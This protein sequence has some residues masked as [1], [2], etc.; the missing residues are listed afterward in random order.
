MLEVTGAPA[1]RP[2][3]NSDAPVTSSWPVVRLLLRL[4]VALSLVGFAF[5]GY[6]W[7]IYP[8]SPDARSSVLGTVGLALGLGGAVVMAFTW[9]YLRPLRDALA[10]MAAGRAPLERLALNAG[11]RAGSLPLLGAI[12][13]ALFW[14]LGGLAVRPTLDRAGLANDAVNAG[15]VAG[16]CTG[17]ISSLLYYYQAVSDL[18]S[19]RLRLPAGPSSSHGAPIRMRVLI[20]SVAVL[21]VGVA[22]VGVSGYLNHQTALERAEVDGCSRALQGLVDLDAP[23]TS[24][25]QAASIACGGPAA[26]A[27][28]ER[29]LVPWELED[30]TRMKVGRGP[31]GTLLRTPLQSGANLYVLVA[32][33]HREQASSG[34]AGQMLLFTLIALVLAVSVALVASRAIT[35][36]VRGLAEGAEAVAR[37]DLTREVPALSADEIGSLARSF[38]AM[39]GGLRRTV[40]NISRAAQALSEQISLVAGAGARVRRGMEARRE[41]VGRIAG[42]MDDMDRSVASVGREVSG[43]S[44]YVASTGATLAEFSAALDEVRRHGQELE[45]AVRDARVE[46]KALIAAAEATRGEIGNLGDAARS[47]LATAGQSRQTLK[48]LTDTALEIQRVADL[49]VEETEEGARVVDEGV[50]G[51]EAIRGVVAEARQRVVALGKRS[52]DITAVIDFI[53]DVAG[54]TNL[55]SLNAAIIAAQAGEQGKAFGVVADQIRELS[56]QIGSSTKRIA[57]NIAGVGVEVDLT[58]ALIEQSDELAAVGVDR[59]REGGLALG[60]IAESA[61]QARNVAAAIS[62]AVEAHA[63][64]SAQIEQLAG[65]VVELAQGFMGADLLGRGGQSIEALAQSLTPLTERIGR[66]LEEQSSVS[67]RQVESLE[68]INRMITR[69][70]RTIALHGEGTARALK[71]L[72]ELVALTDEDS[73]AADE[74]A[75]AAHALTEHAATLREG[76]GQFRI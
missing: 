17:L 11:A 21:L 9:A 59:A 20:T 61:R 29:V 52:A 58:R 75:E 25:V 63:A 55:L 32:R 68:E 44:E 15:L 67:H 1:G 43:L 49:L 64:T 53:A 72:S 26:L 51:V 65:R 28:G 30:P 48:A 40:G 33:A 69:I 3:M 27:M 66:A 16:L 70:N 22:M 23:A 62:P 45:R 46:L 56:A 13:I 54:R 18:F 4:A 14:L 6:L 35:A 39:S 41:G 38:Q 19:L 71:R 34:F 74:L 7:L 12:L 8:L 2:D 47:T 24:V 5:V 37:G 36:P 73:R 10:E 31:K 76:L 50:R 42:E 57:D 60:R